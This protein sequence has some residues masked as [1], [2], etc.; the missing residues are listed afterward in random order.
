MI[1]TKARMAAKEL[2]KDVC[3]VDGEK[4]MTSV[5]IDSLSI[6]DFNLMV[7]SY[8]KNFIAASILGTQQKLN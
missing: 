8:L 2:F 6:D 4:K 1:I 7:G 5:L 3:F